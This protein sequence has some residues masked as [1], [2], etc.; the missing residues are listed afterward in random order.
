MLRARCMAA[1][2]HAEKLGLIDELRT[3]DEYLRTRQ[4]DAEVLLLRQKS[5][6]KREG[7]LAVLNRVDAALNAAAH[8]ATAVA[9]AVA[10]PFGWTSQLNDGH[11]L[12]TPGRYND[13]SAPTPLEPFAAAV[14]GSRLPLLRA[15]DGPLAGEAQ[16]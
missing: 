5:P 4:A 1:G 16:R 14:A 10:S 15:G 3:S 2:V 11:Q 8:A 6:A 7:L 13:A 12:P 9:R